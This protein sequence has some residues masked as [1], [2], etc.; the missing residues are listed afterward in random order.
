MSIDPQSGHELDPEFNQIVRMLGGTQD[1]DFGWV[2]LEADR[3]MK[4]LALGRDNVSGA[5]AFSNVAGYENIIQILEAAE[6]EFLDQWMSGWFFKPSNVE[7]LYSEDVN[8]E[9]N[10]FVFSDTAVQLVVNPE[11]TSD[12]PLIE[13]AAQD[14]A[15]W[16]T[17][18]YDAIALESLRTYDYLEEYP[19]GEIGASRKIFERLDQVAKAVGF[20]R[21]LFDNNIPVDFSWIDNYELPV[22]NTPLE[23]ETLYY[24]PEVTVAGELFTIVVAGG[25]S[26]ETENLYL[27][28]D[29]TASDTGQQAL[30]DRN[31]DI[32]QQGW[33]TGD[34]GENTAVA[35]SLN[36]TFTDGLDSRFEIDLNYQS[37][38][39]MP[40]MFARYYN[41]ADTTSGILGH[42]WQAT[43]YEIQF[44]HPEF[45]SS[46]SAGETS[47]GFELSNL[48]GLRTGQLR[49]IDRMSGQAF[50]FDSSFATDWRDDVGNDGTLEFYF[51]GID[52]SVDSDVP[53]F[54]PATAE[55]SEL[56]DGSSLAQDSNTRNFTLTRRDGS[57]VTFDRN[58]QIV[59][60]SDNRGRVIEFD[61]SG[62]ELNSITESIGETVLQEM[63]F[64]YSEGRISR[65]DRPWRRKS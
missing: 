64:S 1:T 60:M 57:S 41:S 36:S 20:A 53:E 11:L 3:V 2:M 59:S 6:F 30:D 47:S 29:G 37:V 51:E 34:N 14:F 23:I 54:N 25:A 22:R 19:G 43:P 15:D 9:N 49:I 4:T 39:K 18:N 63:S 61:F 32:S 65:V 56:S 58:G 38:G 5:P 26:F 52:T 44:S 35:L 28:D 17:T 33:V 16:F 42:G 46:D 50:T 7:L 21:F 10:S 27:D 40:F 45:Y 55:D 31:G 13:Q 24:K 12:D 8:Q 48:N 62:D